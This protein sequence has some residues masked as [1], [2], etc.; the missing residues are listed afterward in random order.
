MRHKFTVST[1]EEATLHSYND[2]IY[3]CLYW[4]TCNAKETQ[5]QWA[6]HNR[7]TS[8]KQWIGY[9]WKKKNG[10]STGSFH[11]VAYSEC[12]PMFVNVHRLIARAH[13]HTPTI[14]LKWM[15]WIC[16]S[17]QIFS[18]VN[19]WKKEEEEGL[20]SPQSLVRYQLE[21]RRRRRRRKAFKDKR[22]EEKNRAPLADRPRPQPQHSETIMHYRSFRR[23]RHLCVLF[24]CA[25]SDVFLW[26]I[27]K[28]PSQRES[29]GAKKGTATSHT[30]LIYGWVY[31]TLC[32]DYVEDLHWRHGS[33]A[34]H[35]TEAIHRA[36]I[37]T[38][39]YD[40]NVRW[41]TEK[42][43]RKKKPSHHICKG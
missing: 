16:S 13:T 40:N 37:S 25:L 26:T 29:R 15:C 8:K 22:R 33:G 9:I 36:F 38:L 20:E 12:M 6:A 28:S 41:M 43:E 11:F 27:L 23:F 42:T 3:S 39:A 2:S 7:T 35:W 34:A 4:I 21:A 17:E 31:L 18:I 32:V 1:L 24:R 5:S 30:Q 19:E 14:Q 10:S